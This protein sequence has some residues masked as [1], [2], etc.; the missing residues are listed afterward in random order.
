[1]IVGW[2]IDGV[3]YPWADAANEAVAEKFGIPNPGDHLVWGHLQEV[4]PDEAWRWLWKKEG[5]DA[6]FSQ[7]ERVYPDAVEAVRR[8][9]RAKGTHVHFVT[10]RDP[11]RTTGF[12]A[13]FL[14]RHFGRM[15]WAGVHV[16]DASV[17]KWSLL[18]WDVFADDK[19]QTCEEMLFNTSAQV[20][21]PARPW[22][23]PMEGFEFNAWPG[24]RNRF[25]RYRTPLEVA[26]WI[27]TNRPA[28]R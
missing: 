22:N 12:T 23:E 18:P 6:I 3:L 11:V 25:L 15:K 28:G 27:E 13:A 2:D 14:H 17:D 8:S 24:G 1:V 7:T 21:M 10:H 5:Q 26:E 20:F 16:L 4:L 9:M 19:I